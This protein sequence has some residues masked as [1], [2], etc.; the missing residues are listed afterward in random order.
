MLR[1]HIVNLRCGV[2]ATGD[3]VSLPQS[4]ST[5]FPSNL[6]CVL[7]PQRETVAEAEASFLG[8]VGD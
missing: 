3:A 1:K 6:L 2:G 5:W 7:R 4:V 8:L